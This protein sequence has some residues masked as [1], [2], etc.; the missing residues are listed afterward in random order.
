MVVV[1]SSCARRQKIV[2]GYLL[3]MVMCLLPPLVRATAHLQDV[4][5]SPSTFR[6][7]RGF[8]VPASKWTADP[9]VRDSLDDTVTTDSSRSWPP[10]HTGVD[11][12]LLPNHQHDRCPDPLRGPPSI[13]FS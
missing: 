3:I 4:I 2:S 13:L 5:R 12:G 1:A 11:A 6:L 7:N 9:L 8:D 10:P